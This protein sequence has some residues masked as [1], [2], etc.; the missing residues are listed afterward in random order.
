M[1]ALQVRS[2]IVCSW[3]QLILCTASAKVATILNPGA[4]IV[5]SLLVPFQ[6]ILGAKPLLAS[7]IRDVA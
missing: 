5:Y 2:E 4:F 3:P 1:D 6:I 7:T